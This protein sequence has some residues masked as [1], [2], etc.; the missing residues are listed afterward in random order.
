MHRNKT[1]LFLMVILAIALV[2]GCANEESAVEGPSS[3]ET[4]NIEAAAIVNG[5]AIP[6]EDYQSALDQTFAAYEQNGITFDT[7]ETKDLEKEI[8]DQV[9]NSLV[10]N[11]ILL[12]EARNE[13]FDLSEEQLESEFET[14]KGQFPTQEEFEMALGDAG[15]TEDDLR[16]LI[17]EE[18]I[19][20]DYLMSLVKDLDVT[21]EEITAYYESASDAA[22]DAHEAEASEEPFTYPSL[23]EVEGDIENS[24]LQEKQQGV[25]QGILEELR[26]GADI[27]ILI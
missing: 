22:K 16:D 21:R 17:R 12:Q 10:D 1:V 19:R 18:N 5:V 13:G 2:A 6:M 26:D 3:E 24:L 20:N 8:T 15:F 9:I 25:I 4:T 14:V 7:E 27:E 23:E 11:E